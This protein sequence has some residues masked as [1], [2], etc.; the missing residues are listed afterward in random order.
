MLPIDKWFPFS[1]SETY[2]NTASLV[3]K[4]RLAFSVEIHVTLLAGVS[5]AK[6][7]QAMLRVF[8]CKK[9]K[10]DSNA[11]DSFLFGMFLM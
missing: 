2:R 1:P 6:R 3:F 11:S 8:Q 10:R 7:E 9:A 5:P 4:S